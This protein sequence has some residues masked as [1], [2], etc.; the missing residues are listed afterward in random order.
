MAY[1]T[2]SLNI[3]YSLKTQEQGIAKISN[4]ASMLCAR[5]SY[6]LIFRDR[7]SE[8]LIYGRGLLFMQEQCKILN[9][10]RNRAVYNIYRNGMKV[11]IKFCILTKIITS[12]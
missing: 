4:I 3:L 6:V 12:F 8:T 1:D 7:D 10:V 9:L 5:K 11:F 2:K